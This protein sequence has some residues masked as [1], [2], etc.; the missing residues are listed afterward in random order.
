MLGLSCFKVDP[1]P[2][3]SLKTWNLKKKIKT[4]KQTIKTTDYN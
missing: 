3:S 1:H 2:Q 4:N